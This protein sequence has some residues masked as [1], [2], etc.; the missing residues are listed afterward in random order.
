ML[1]ANNTGT[2]NTVQLLPQLSPKHDADVATWTGDSKATTKVRQIEKADYDAVNKDYTESVDALGRAIG[3][4]KK[5]DFDGEHVKSLAEVAA[6]SYVQIH[7]L[8][9]KK[10]GSMLIATQNTN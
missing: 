5:Q 4:L 6:V 10:C 3:A 2:G 9:L 8:L 1:M 7:A